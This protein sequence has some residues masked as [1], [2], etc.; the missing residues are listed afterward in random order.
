MISKKKVVF[1]GAPGTGKGTVSQ[2]LHDHYNFVHLSTGDMFRQMINNNSLL[3]EKLNGYLQEGKYVPDEI[4]N[5]VVKEA[6]GSILKEKNEPLLIFDGYPRTL[7]QAK[8]LDTLINID[9]AILLEPTNLDMIVGRLASRLVCP[10]C[11]KVFGSKDFDDPNSL[12]LC[13]YDKTLLV[14]RK[15]DDLNVIKHRIVEYQKSIKSVIDFYKNKNILFTID[16]NLL[17]EDVI[18]NVLK[19]LKV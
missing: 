6:L 10:K 3:G 5:E 8:Y 15:D 9:I 19:L 16:A 4:T 1:L 13:A 17:A 18:E 7:D 12:K 2:F 14:S 11:Q